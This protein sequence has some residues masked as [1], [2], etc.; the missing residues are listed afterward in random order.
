MIIGNGLVSSVFNKNK[1]DYKN[2]LVFAS[3]VSNS[4]ETNKEQFIREKELI[5]KSI[6]ENKDLTFL[7]FSSVLV[8]ITNNDYYNHKLA[9]EELIKK[10]TDDYVIFRVPQII[11][12]LGNKNNLVNYLRDSIING[13]EITIR[14]R[15]QRALIDIEDLEK[16]V[17][18]CK[19]ACDERTLFLSHI[20][21]TD[22]NEL[23]KIIS[24]K[25]KIPAITKMDFEF[26]DDNWF[27]E[28]STTIRHAIECHEINSVG[29]TEK[30]IKKYI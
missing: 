12:N 13:S 25:L 19:D 18:Y 9:M 24:D 21:K 6:N 11:G 30:I 17:N 20:E 7:Y 29:Y 26:S 27:E 1:K 10:E 5:L 14:Q 23:V 16:I 15:V 28:N 4:K 2:Y 8:G 3:G 22:I